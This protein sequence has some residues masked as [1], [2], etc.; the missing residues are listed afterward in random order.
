MLRDGDLESKQRSF[1]N[2]AIS[3]RPIDLSLP[4]GN[5]PAAVLRPV[6]YFSVRLLYCLRSLLE[7]D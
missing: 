7:A 3:E 1:L 6:L 5:K 2:W 4:H